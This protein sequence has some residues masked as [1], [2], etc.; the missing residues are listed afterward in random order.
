MDQALELARTI[1]KNAPLSLRSFKELVNRAREVS[2]S[3]AAL[4]TREAYDRLLLSKDAKEG[5]RAFAEKRAP[6]WNAE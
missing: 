4:L 6:V 2:E 1:L 3:D 5:P